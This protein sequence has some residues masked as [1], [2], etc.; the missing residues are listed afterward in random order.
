[1]KKIIPFL[2]FASILIFFN[3]SKDDDSNTSSALCLT[4]ISER[5][6]LDPLCEGVP[7]PDNGQILTSELL[8]A[9]KV[10]FELV[11]ASCTLK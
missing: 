9:I 7:N 1:M 4:C 6:T 8:Q 11:G 3:C 2:L 10:T 5:E